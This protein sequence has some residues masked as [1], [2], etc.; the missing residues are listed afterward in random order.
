MKTIKSGFSVNQFDSFQDFLW[1]AEQHY[2]PLLDKVSHN[3]YE[4][5]MDDKRLFGFLYDDMKSMID[6]YDG[7]EIES[8]CH[9]KKKK[10]RRIKS[11]VDGKFSYLDENVQ[12]AVAEVEKYLGIEAEP[13]DYYAYFNLYEDNLTDKEN[14]DIER[15]CGKYE[16]EFVPLDSV[17]DE[18]KGFV[19]MSY[20]DWNKE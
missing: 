6:S 9:G 10:A 1:Y 15:I 13:G 7:T 14:S 11:S 20:D 8:A 18:D 2:L 5:T 19:I 17:G 3:D 12:D 4:L 16:V